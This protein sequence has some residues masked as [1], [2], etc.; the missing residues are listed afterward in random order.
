M[1]FLALSVLLFASLHGRAEE[2]KSLA[3]KQK[4]YPALV[5]SIETKR[6]KFSERWNTSSAD[7]QASLLVEARSFLEK[8]ITEDLFPCWMGTTWD[9]NGVSQKPGESAIACGY[10]VSTILRD[11]GYK[12]ER[13]KLGQQAS[14]VIIKT[15]T[16]DDQIKITSNSSMENMVQV[17][18]NRGDGVYIVGLDSHTGFVTVKGDTMTFVHSNY[19]T[20]PRAVCAE[21]LQGRNPFADSKYRVIGKLA[22]DE[23]I[24]RW[25][26]GAKI[27]LRK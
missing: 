14:Q 16:T 26:T 5:A 1:K 21:P 4:A 2:T 12:V 18:K 17:F 6:L 11:A 7:Q 19:Y 20:P 9:F 23:S 13:A 10:F 24:K 3:E 8:T 25:I 27:E 15:M 22:G